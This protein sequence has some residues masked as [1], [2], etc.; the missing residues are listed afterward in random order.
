MLNVQSAMHLHHCDA[1]VIPNKSSW[2][3]DQHCIIIL[4]A[5]LIDQFC[6]GTIKSSILVRHS[7]LL[8]ERIVM[9]NSASLRI[10][11]YRYP[12]KSLPNVIHNNKPPTWS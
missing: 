4:I 12:C 5:S 9:N 6:D 11:V 2:K 10:I 8:V 7:L 3:A 1:K